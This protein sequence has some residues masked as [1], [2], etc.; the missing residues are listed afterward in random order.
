M[1]QKPEKEEEHEFCV[2]SGSP[3]RERESLPRCVCVLEGDAAR[4]KRLRVKAG[5]NP[6]NSC[7][8]QTQSTWNISL[9]LF[10]VVGPMDAF[11]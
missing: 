6:N 3:E 8:S 4:E 1:N 5:L 2:L 11:F 7:Y 10:V 9:H